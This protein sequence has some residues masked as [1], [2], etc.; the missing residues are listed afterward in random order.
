MKISNKIKY[1]FWDVIAR[2]V[3]AIPPL[4]TTIYFFPEW[5][6]KSASATWSGMIIVVIL[7]LMIP[8]WKKI[9]AWA[10]EFTLTN[11]S[12]PILWLVLT[13]FCYLMQYISDK[14]LCISI[15]GLVGSL[16]S[17]GI[18]IIRNKY[19]DNKAEDKEDKKE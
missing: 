2:I 8:L 1:E 4:I 19:R 16:L 3:S 12:M 7:V 11:A 18:C 15:A 5:V 17:T 13:G 14:V 9:F 10:K 6:K